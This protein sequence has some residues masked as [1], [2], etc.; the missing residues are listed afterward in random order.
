L[1]EH[2]EKTLY[3][4]YKLLDQ[5]GIYI[6]L[7]NILSE[8]KF[9][10][11]R[12]DKAYTNFIKELFFNSIYLH[13]IGKINPAFQYKKM[14]NKLEQ[15]KNSS[16][17]NDSRHSLLSALIF[18]DIYLDRIDQ[19]IDDDIQGFIRHVLYSFSYIISRHHTHLTNLEECNYLHKLKQIQ[20]MVIEEPSY[21]A[22]YKNSDHIRKDDLNKLQLDTYRYHS[23][24]EPYEFY[25][26]NRLLYSAITGCDFYATYFY[27]TGSEPKFSYIENVNEIIKT[28]QETEI[29]KGI[30]AYKQ[31]N[32]YFGENSINT[33]RS[34]IFLECEEAILNNLYDNYIFYLEAPTGSGKTNTSINLAL[35]ILKKIPEYNK[36]T[37]V[38]PFNT[39]V[40]Q[41]KKTL[42]EIFDKNTQGSIKVAVINSITPIITEEEK[43]LNDET[44]RIDYKKDYLNRQMIHYPVSLTT[45]VNFFNYLFGTGREINLPLIHLC[46]SVII[47]DEIQSYRNI[48]WPEIIKLLNY[49]SKL[50]NMKIIIMSATLP[51]L[52]ELLGKSKSG[53]FELMKKRSYYYEHRLF[54]DRVK[55]NFDLLG[56]KKISEEELMLKIDEIIDYQ[57]YCRM[58]IEFITKTTARYFFE[59]LKKK[60]PHKKVFELT[61]DDSNYTRDKILN[62][63]NEL[64]YN[65]NFICKDVIVVATQ[66]IESGVN[67]DMDVG[68]KDISLLDGEEQFLGRINRSC[69]KQNCTAYFFDYDE[70]KKVYREDFRLENDLTNPQYQQYLISKN[71]KEF[72]KTCFKRLEEIKSEKNK[73]NI[74]NLDEA[75]LYLN[76]QKVCDMMELIK[77]KNCQ[78]FLARIIIDKKT[79]K[80]IDGHEVWK[81][82][83]KLIHNKNME[84]SKRKIK[85]SMISEIMSYFT[86]NY[87]DSSNKH[88]KTPK[89]YDEKIGGLYYKKN[90]AEYIT[91]EGKFDRKKY[92]KD[93]GG[94]FI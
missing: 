69:K 24:R 92:Q 4:F 11:K 31:N 5:K 72:Y 22:Y 93:S 16:R 61:G 28:Y 45:H 12:L 18:I 6:V 94:L 83:K 57:K 17:S 10:G 87:V 15:Y 29:Y 52:D 7:D 21:I 70:A 3:F 66:V 84:Y 80:E 76:Y 88:D 62:E 2:S 59:V 35:N 64:D 48:I 58:L 25:I 54:K 26:L 90:G 60:Y 82:Y 40:E 79:G 20:E 33:L 9:D 74:K 67:I 53:F 23:D 63:I 42:D 78:I 30:K 89:L 41:T 75:V 32:N 71:F 51:K 39:L 68:L 81:Q 8:L 85:L 86:Y 1:I 43:A 73:N 13:D 36:I 14:K 44:K 47:I 55:L 49:Y 77:D 65:G 56:D 50:L 37:Y 19:F 38:F 27:D 91:D 46:N 34:E